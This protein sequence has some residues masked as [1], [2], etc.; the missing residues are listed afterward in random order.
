MENFQAA[1]NSHGDRVLESF[2]DVHERFPV[3]CISPDQSDC[4]QYVHGPCDKSV[5]EN[6]AAPWKIPM[7]F[8]QQGKRSPEEAFL[9]DINIP[10][11]ESDG[12]RNRFICPVMQKSHQLPRAVSEDPYSL[13]NNRPVL[14]T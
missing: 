14:R 5:K 10:T 9:W 11:A 8:F 1:E 12:Y 4:G 3:L 7:R 2:R 6:D 13:I